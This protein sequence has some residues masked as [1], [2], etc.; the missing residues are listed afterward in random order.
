[1]GG[2]QDN[3]V[4]PTATAT[5]SATATATRDP[6]GIP[7]NLMAVVGVNSVTLDWDAP[8]VV[9][10]GYQVRRHLQGEDEDEELRPIFAAEV[11]DPTTYIDNTVAVAGTYEYTVQ[12]IFLD[13]SSYEAS[14]P[15]TVIVRESDLATQTATATATDT[16]TETS[17]PTDTPTPDT[18]RR[19]IRPHKLIHQ[20]EPTRQRR[21]QPACRR[22]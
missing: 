6:A 10:D 1:M 11:D 3:P 19:P 16:V 15:V 12:S 7:L 2:G 5:A 13:G 9:P 17:T 20:R 14:Q 8:P 22:T 18:P 21:P 4:D